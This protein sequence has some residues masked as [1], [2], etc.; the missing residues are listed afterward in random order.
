M[1]KSRLWINLLIVLVC[2]F[3]DLQVMAEEHEAGEEWFASTEGSVDGDVLT[4]L[5][6]FFGRYRPDSA[7]DMLKQ[8]PG[9]RMAFSGE[10]R[11]YSSSPG[12]VLIDG[13]R[14]SSKRVTVPS[15][16]DRIPAS[17]VDRIELIRGPVRNIEL[18]GEPQVANVVLKTDTPAAV[19]WSVLGYRNSDMNPLPW[20]TNISLS[21][22]WAGIDYNA[23]LNIFRKSFSERNDE[24]I[25]DGNGN[26]VERR[27][28][29]GYD[30]ELEANFDLTASAWMG[31]TLLTWNSQFGI[32]DG[33]RNF[34]SHRTPSTAGEIGQNEFIKG[35][36]DEFQL[37][38]G[39]TAERSLTQDLSGYL[40]IFF[41][42]ENE[43]ETTIQRSINFL[44]T[45]ISE[46]YKV[47]KQHEK[48]AIVRTE[49]DWT[50][51][52]AHSVKL[53]IEGSY[54]LVDNAET[55]TEDTGAGPVEIIV[56]GA[57]TKIEEYRGDFLLKDIWTLGKFEL[58]YGLG[59]EVSRLSQS[60]EDNVERNLFYFKPHAEL[61]YTPAE[62]QK[63]RIR[64]ARE[65]AQLLFDDFIS[66]SLYLDDYIALGN[67][68]LRPE[69]TWISDLGYE[70]RFWRQSVFKLNLFHHW[71]TDV[72]DLI[73]VTLT[74]SAPGNIGDGRRWG[75]SLEGAFELDW[76]GLQNARLDVNARWQN[77][78]VNDPI[79]GSKRVLTATI[80]VDGNPRSIFMNDNEYVLVIDFRHDIDDLRLA[81]G[82]DVTI[83]A[84]LPVFKV[85]EFDNWHKDPVAN[86]F[87]E[88]TRWFGVKVRFE[89]N[90][91]LDRTK[92]RERVFYAGQRDLSP[93]LRRQ[94][95][96][97]TDG[98]EIGLSLSGSF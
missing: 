5:A 97:R 38:A 15:I 45:Q 61:S 63:L 71:I 23:G 47:E 57:T 2:L 33:A 29:K 21:D 81:W 82:W 43:N 70:R 53:N 42:R 1:S 3:P 69:A 54:N 4:Y 22:R 34:D 84:D 51:W 62:K 7:L 65:I 85:N 94:I 44:D 83:E 49:F 10:L 59:A 86:I 93:V 46:R 73:P 36:S 66:A 80:L 55:D 64:I 14:P 50:G 98:R 72:Q 52:S 75:I 60:G 11:G 13:R 18:L 32:Q 16:L 90:N 20:F 8:L 95:Q 40:L 27:I 58:D 77:S 78:S 96:K 48:E 24:R 28:E 35:E 68:D 89:F 26:L 17:Q 39:I 56:P 87:V 12:N 79:T 19:R 88:T 9:F 76:L 67:P 74:G 31:E 25:V 91:I 92:D 6:T 41:S 37:E 30:K